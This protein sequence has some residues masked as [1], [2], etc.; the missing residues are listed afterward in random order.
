MRREEEVHK[1][2]TKFDEERVLGK[3]I[4]DTMS[5]YMPLIR[6]Q[7]GDEKTAIAGLLQT[8]YTLHTSDL[9]TK[10]RLIQQLAQQHGVDLGQ[11]NAQPVDQTVH[12]LQNE[13]QQLKQYIQSQQVNTEQQEQAQIH[14]TIDS[15]A[16]KPENIYF[17]DVKPAMAALL[18]EGQAK[19]LQEAYDMACWARPDIRPLMLQSQQKQTAENVREKANKARNAAVSV[20]GSPVSSTGN[21]SQPASTLA[22][23]L[24]NQF[25]A[26]SGRV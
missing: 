18:K 4:K 8:A 22:D 20:T 25:A 24:R 13:L 15:F 10:T 3:Q 26:A 23:E 7:G 19:D 21:S 16:S 17:H 6:S 11:N 12:Q 2:F 9:P 14:S 5:P 1:G